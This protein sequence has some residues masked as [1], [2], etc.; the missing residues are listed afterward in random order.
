MSI[1]VYGNNL[2]NENVG[3]SIVTA[4]ESGGYTLKTA[5]WC[6]SSLADGYR[7]Q[8]LTQGHPTYRGMATTQKEITVNDSYSGIAI[9]SATFYGALTTATLASTAAAPG[10]IATSRPLN[11][12]QS[13]YEVFTLQS[14]QPISL[15]PTAIWLAE[16]PPKTYDDRIPYT[17]PFTQSDIS[18]TL[19]LSLYPVIESVSFTQVANGVYECKYLLCVREIGAVPIGN[20]VA[21]NLWNGFASSLVTTTTI[22]RPAQPTFFDN[23][24]KTKISLAGLTFGNGLDTQAAAAGTAINRAYY[25]TGSD[26][27]ILQQGGVSAQPKIYTYGPPRIIPEVAAQAAET[28]QD[29]GIVIA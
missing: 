7:T 12:V 28:T 15:P 10:R 4:T 17:N 18:Y 8:L 13:E 1:I 24:P 11:Y 27:I 21:V 20:P 16:I 3:A 26:L 6:K 22:S 19:R 25:R 23:T 29:V 14:Y 2:L 9:I 5:F